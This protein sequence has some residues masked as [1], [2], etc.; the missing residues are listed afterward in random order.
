[1]ANA[2][3]TQGNVERLPKKMSQL[4]VNANPDEGKAT[5]GNSFVIEGVISN[6]AR[7]TVK[8]R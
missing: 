1:M 5:N 2:P 8:L 3:S 7:K 4:L 6:R